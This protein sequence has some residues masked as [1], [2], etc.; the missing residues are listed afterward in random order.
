MSTDLWSDIYTGPW[1]VTGNIAK[2]KTLHELH[3]L[4]ANNAHLSIL[5]IGCVGP[6]PLA[7]WEP[8]LA[9]CG[10]HFHL[11]GIDIQGIEKARDLVTQRGWQDRVTLQQGSGYNLSKLF[12]PQSFHVVV[13]TQVLEHVAHLSLFMQQVATVLRSGGAGFFAVDSAHWQSRFDLRDPIRCAKNLLKKSLS[14]LG[15]ERHYD[16]PWFDHE[17]T[18]ASQKAGL[19]IVECRYYN[20]DPLKFIHNHVVPPL[21]QNAFMQ[22]WFALEEFLNEEET[23]QEQAKH[24]FM[25]LYLHMH[26]P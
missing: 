24:C 12:A 23:V 16:L 8:I 18:V 19:E 15:S 1:I 25:G 26:K 4:I 3:R 5:D 17:V 20:L 14:W 9:S 6:Q 10:L 2:V 11:T 22:L 7:F 21:H 13:A